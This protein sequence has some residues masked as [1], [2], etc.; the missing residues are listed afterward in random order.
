[1]KVA[2]V[3]SV[4]RGYRKA[5]GVSQKDLAVMAGISRATLNYLESGRDLEI[6]AGKLL[7]LLDLLGIPFVLPPGVDREHD[8]VVLE[9]VA[10]AAAGKGKL[11]RKTVVEALA[12]GRVPEGADQALRSLLDDTPE[13]DVLA[14]VRSVSAGS[15]QTPKAIWKNGRALAKSLGCE[16]RVWLHDGS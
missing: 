15:G 10:R 14:V 8:D 16:R 7:A 9:R 5:S 4:V 3:G 12:T 11:P 13:P 2:A 6:G 1:M